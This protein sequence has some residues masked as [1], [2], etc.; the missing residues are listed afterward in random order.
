M[1]VRQ[2][3][4]DMNAHPTDPRRLDRAY[5]ALAHPVRR[6][7]LAHQ[8]ETGATVTTVDALAGYLASS[9]DA[10]DEARAR[11]LLHHVHLPKLRELGVVEYDERSGAV[12]YSVPDAVDAV[13]ASAAGRDRGTGS[14]LEAT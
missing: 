5:H 1:A 2:R 6:A 10:L 13:F 12:R 14:S 11:T 3:R 9:F 7:V 8:R 4:S